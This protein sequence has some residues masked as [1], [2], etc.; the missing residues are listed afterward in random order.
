MPLAIDP[1][2]NPT[3]GQEPGIFLSGF[4]KGYRASGEERPLISRL[5]L[6]AYRLTVLGQAGVAIQ[7]EAP[8]P[9][10]FRA[11]LNMLRKYAKT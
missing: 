8:L 4:K 10:D 11:V 9:K 2:Y 6:H 7:I 1:L 5:T 3:H